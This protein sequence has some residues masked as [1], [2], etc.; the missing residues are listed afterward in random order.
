[1]NSS[2]KLIKFLAFSLVFIFACQQN[3]PIVLNTDF[4][5]EFKT[6]TFG[7]GAGYL[8]SNLGEIRTDGK[9][10]FRDL[11]VED[12]AKILLCDYQKINCN[13]TSS[14]VV[15]KNPNKTLANYVFIDDQYKD[16][17]ADQAIIAQAIMKKL[18]EAG[19]LTVF[20]RIKDLPRYI[21]EEIDENKLNRHIKPE[22][23][24]YQDQRRCNANQTQRND[25]PSKAVMKSMGTLNEFIADLSFCLGVDIFI[26]EKIE[27]KKIANTNMLLS[28]NTTDDEKE[29]TNKLENLGITAKK[30]MVKSKYLEVNITPKM[31]NL[32]KEGQKRR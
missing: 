20:E 12:A 15:F 26:D 11:K 14:K 30:Y 27:K 18:E 23:K 19:V 6:R 13:G 5:A 25:N 1:M 32:T 8:I 17:N 28:I 4:K 31:I 2:N 16:K 9:I 24:N 29:L 22:D 3:A 10:N 7:G 21:I